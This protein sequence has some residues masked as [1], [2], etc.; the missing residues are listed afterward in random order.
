MQL[1]RG[2]LLP[3]QIWN[4]WVLWLGRG[5]A[6]VALAVMVAVILAQVWFRYVL[7]N[8]LPW[9]D[10][11]ARFLMLWMTGL[12]APS[13]LRAGGFVAIDML[14]EALPRRLA[15]IVILV[16]LGL[17]MT[18]LLMGIQLGWNHVNSGWLFASSSLRLPLDLVG[19]TSIKIKLAWM[20]MS[21]FVGMVLMAIVNV[22]LILR[23][24]LMIA[25]RAEGL[26]PL[27]HSDLPEAE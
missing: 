9:P 22:E 15:D 25:G 17:A 19:G 6:I 11:A 23:R 2:I 13:G 16:L 12:A 21:I 14:T 4:D 3:I 7:N 10:E 24:I 26:P 1:I 5:L 20:Y 8:A 27:S 18:V